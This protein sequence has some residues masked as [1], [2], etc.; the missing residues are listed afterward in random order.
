MRK[1]GSHRL[2]MAWHSPEIVRLLIERGANVNFV[3]KRG[4]TPLMAVNHAES[5][6]LLVEA[7]ARIDA[8]DDHRFTA[9]LH[10]ID[11]QNH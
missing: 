3:A 10:S 9:L 6:R 8:I 5:A 1:L 4:L 7:G 2:M 11:R